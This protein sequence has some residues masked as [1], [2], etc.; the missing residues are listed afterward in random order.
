MKGHRIYV[1]KVKRYKKERMVSGVV[2]AAA[3]KGSNI[4]AILSF[5]SNVSY[6]WYTDM[7]VI[8]YISISSSIPLH[9]L[10]VGL[11][12]AQLLNH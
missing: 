10:S 6:P 8:Y 1:S 7:M 4:T 5:L 2:F 11:R 9:Q 3:F 12:A